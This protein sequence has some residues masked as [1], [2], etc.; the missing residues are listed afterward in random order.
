M[1]I[2]AR[3]LCVLTLV[4]S[5]PS[6]TFASLSASPVHGTVTDASG[7]ALVR[8]FVR[9]VDANGTQ[10]AAALTDDRGEF[11]IDVTA[12]SGCRLEAS[13]EGFRTAT[14]AISAAQASDARFA[15]RL[16]L[17][18]A[19][20][21]DAVLV[22]P[23]RDAAP[24]SQSGASFS[25]FTA[26]DIARRG[27]PSVADLLR[28][29]PGVSVI[30]SGGL[31]NVTSLF[32]RGGESSY[33]KVLLDGV[34][35]NEPGGTFNFGNLST[36]NLERV[37]V[38]RGA[39]SALFGSD[40]MSGVIQLL[41][42][43]GRASARPAISASF[44][45]GTYNTRRSSGS[46]SG[47]RAGWD[48]SI[49]AERLDTDNRAPK[50]AFSNSTMSWSGGGAVA[51]SVTIRTNGRV[52]AGTVGVPGATE[53]GRPDSDAKFDRQD[54]TAGLS[55]E[56]RISAQ[57]KQRASYAF[58]RS[59]QESTNL[60]ADPAY[61]PTYGASSSPFA[62][63]DFTYNSQNIL[64]RHFLSYQV[65][66]RFTGRVNQFVTAAVDWDGER[67]TLNDRLANTSLAASR[68]N[69]G[70]SVQH[71]LVLP[72]LSVTSSLRFEHNDSFGDEWVPR[73]SAAL[74]ANHSTGVIGNT[75]LK[76]S[77]A[78]GVKEPTVLQSFSP[79]IG[80]LGNPDLLPERARTW[81]AGIE[82]RL[83]DDHVR[84][85]ATY[86]D[87]RYENQISTKTLGFNPFRSQY[88]NKLGFTNA[89]GIE[90]AAEIAPVDTI[91][92]SGG[93]SFLNADVFDRATSTSDP[94]ALASALIRR[95]RHSAYGRAAWTWKGASLDIDASYVGARLDND[96]SSLSPALT[97]S[98]NYWLWNAAG[99]YR[100]T[101]H[102]EGFA[103]VQNLADRNYME[104]LGYPA[105][106]RTVHIG[107]N[108]KF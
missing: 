52:E 64:R 13:L 1:G 12:C 10:R 48:Y 88:V 83:A 33:T 76:G 87:N 66:G 105:W 31:G 68:N 45:G 90:L 102:I 7:A 56:H 96:F 43:Q 82:Q 65:D 67:D 49:G 44:E 32:M 40:A 74:I 30:R 59:N 107:L 2:C 55:I 106:G 20:I 95:P 53:F 91:R 73:I 51:P 16:S 70:V 98:G 81:E 103:R 50:N 60:I 79:N 80:F 35:M 93:Y 18:I 63:S 99:R 9:L 97:S 78:K 61:T 27:S 101:P 58:T 57:W 75:T 21:T 84:V 25:V 4:F 22:T 46:L 94:T 11:S 23:T 38:V 47:G 24:A 89:K 54:I 108:V 8:A 85:E 36:A 72:R 100:I 29:T 86:F 34:P 42:K 62:F 3:A 37:E 92:L 15:P 17:A 14:L 71:Q 6:P 26:D 19:P 104:P 39:Q 41:T 5:L 77:A 69:T 28:E